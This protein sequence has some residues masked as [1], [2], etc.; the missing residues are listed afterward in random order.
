MSFL[1]SPSHL[2]FGLPNG[3]VNIGFHLSSVY[4]ICMCIRLWKLSRKQTHNCSDDIPNFRPCVEI[5]IILLRHYRLRH[6]LL[7]LDSKGKGL[8]VDDTK[9][10]RGIRGIAQP[11]RVSDE[12]LN[13]YPGKEHRYP[14]NRRLGRPHGLSGHFWEEENLLPLPAFEPQTVQPLA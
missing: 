7:H 10:Q 13:S 6:F 3:L 4:R 14:L 8:P 12:R 11:I 9:A 1:V 2:F 5:L